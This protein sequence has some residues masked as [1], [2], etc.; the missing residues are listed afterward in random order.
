MLSSWLSLWLAAASPVSAA[1]PYAS[2][3]PVPSHFYESA[4]Q[5]FDADLRGWQKG[6]LLQLNH[7]LF[8][9]TQVSA[10]PTSNQMMM[11]TGYTSG[12]PGTVTMTFDS[13]DGDRVFTPPG[14]VTTAR[15]DAERREFQVAAAVP[16]VLWG[17]E[18]VVQITFT[19]DE[20]GKRAACYVKA[21]F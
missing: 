19:S 15:V 12:L 16:R 9:L 17:R 7:P 2:G 5:E 6:Q 21:M 3:C 10:G 11:F 1:A 13:L 14:T 8:S 4:T 18:G 20:G